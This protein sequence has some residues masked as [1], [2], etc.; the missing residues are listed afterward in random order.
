MENTDRPA[1][2]VKQFM[3]SRYR[4]PAA[5][6]A[7]RMAHEP[8]VMRLELRRLVKENAW[9]AT[10]LESIGRGGPGLAGR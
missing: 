2:D 1:P 8:T 3:M 10:S 7:R 5:A 9:D 6:Q 4:S